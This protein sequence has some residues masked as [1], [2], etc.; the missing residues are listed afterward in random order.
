MKEKINERKFFN[1]WKGLVFMLLA[2]V[3]YGTST[4]LFLAPNSI[5]A[6]GVSGLAVLINLLTEKI[7]V[8]ALV[9]A[10]NIPILIMGVK[11]YGWK[12]IIKCL[13]TIVCLGVITDLLAMLPALKADPILSALYGG[14]CQ[15]IGIGLWVRY[16]Y[17]SGGTELLGRLVS[18]WTKVLKIPVCVGILDGLI[19][20]LGAIFTQNPN[21]MLYALIVIFGSTKVSEIVI[22]G[23]EKSKLCI[24]I[25]DKGEELSK[26]LVENSPRGVTMLNGQGMYT[27]N[28]H[29]VVLTCVK[30]H[31]LTQLRQI[32]KTVDPSAFIIINDSVEVRGKGFKSMEEIEKI[33]IEKQIKENLEIIENG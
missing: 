16:E 29:K 25:T 18:R 24:I 33:N 31:Q 7:S 28:E 6:G 2:C 9:I 13:L 23:L 26:T 3:A 21:N 11:F 8:G 15:G 27:M 19:V 14:I 10:I 20:I 32:V 12:F 1:D 17:S 30:N 22:T 4:S 5:V